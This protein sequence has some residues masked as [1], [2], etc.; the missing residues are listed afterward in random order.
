ML[1]LDKKADNVVVL[2][3]K[4]LTT[5]ADYFVVCSGES[6]T[7]VRAIAEHVEETLSKLRAKRVLPFSVQGLGYSHW[8]LMDYSDVIVHIFE[9]NTRQYY[10][11]EKLWLDAPRVRIGD[12]TP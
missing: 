10:M 2:E 6:V 8:V 4:G 3:M 1:C 12:N 7:Q 5:F 9:K 11:L